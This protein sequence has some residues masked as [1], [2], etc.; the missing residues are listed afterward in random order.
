MNIVCFG[1]HPD[2]PEFWAGGTL[3]QWRKAGHRVVAVSMTRGDLGH[4]EHTGAALAAIRLAEAEEAAR[5]GSYE[6]VVL[7][8]GDG[9]LFP[10]P[11]VREAVVRL[12]R[13]YRADVVLTHRPWDYHPDHRYAAA[14]VQDAAYMVMVPHY[15]PDTPALPN[16]PVFLYMMDTFTKPVPFQADVA[17]DISDVFEEKLALLDAM[18]SQVYEWLPWIEGRLDAVPA[19]PAARRDWLGQCYGPWF[20]AAANRL[21]TVLESCYGADAAAIRHAEGFELCEYGTRPSRD[22]LLRLFPVPERRVET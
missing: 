18:A 19:D 13:N 5:R 21:R 11:D 8:F 3:L 10:G 12:I 1:A 14:A 16:N 9:Y 4:H 2:D 20:E 15:C 17:V 7:D 6:S 22:A